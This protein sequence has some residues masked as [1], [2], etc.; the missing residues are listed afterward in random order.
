[1]EY[2]KLGKSGLHISALSLGSWVT[3]GKQVDLVSAKELM[4]TAYE[5]GINF[6]DNAEVYAHG[7]SEEIM[8]RV[9]KELA[10]DRDT[11]LLSSKVFF[12]RV[13]DPA[14]TQKGLSRKHITEACHAALKRLQTDYLDLFFCHRPDPE[15]PMEEI[16]FTMDTLIRQ[17]KVLYWG[18]S[19]WSAPAI[20][21]AHAVAEKYNLIAPV[22]EQPHYNLFKRRKVESDYAYLYRTVGLGTTVWSPLASGFLT[23]K[24]IDNLDARGRL[25]LE[26][27]E[28][29][30]EAVLGN[31]P[32]EKI[33]AVRSFVAFA[34]KINVTP[35]Q[36]AIA[37]I[38]TNPN[39]STV[40]LGASGT[41]QLQENLKALD[42]YLHF[43]SEWKEEIEQIMSPVDDIRC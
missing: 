34:R 19:E 41:E 3:F 35:A 33:E 12:G 1:M 8:G 43:D 7:L 15:T 10:W 31:R 13:A 11:Y 24:Y 38:L 23:G 14:P 32:E 4:K 42:V 16:V 25:N 37:W 22:T 6:F 9:L 29:L 40:I 30:K 17:G 28:W 36:L 39:V 2:R 27:M 5:A 21:H 20:M 26:G 18:T